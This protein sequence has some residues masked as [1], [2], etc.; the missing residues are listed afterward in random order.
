[1]KAEI[2]NIGDEILIGQIVNTNATFIAKELSKI[3]VETTQISSIADSHNDIISTLKSAQKR[4]DIIIITGGLGPTKD[5]ITKDALCD[6]F[7]DTLIKREEIVK[8]IESLFKNSIKKTVNAKT[9]NQAILPSKAIVLK[10]ELGTSPGMLFEENNKIFVS[11]PGVPFEMEALIKEQVIPKIKTAF[12]LPYIIHKTFLVY[13]II[14]SELALKLEEWEN[15]L[16]KNLKL[17]YLPSLGRVRLR[18]SG[19]DKNDSLL[20]KNIDKATKGLYNIIGDS[21][22]GENFDNLELML[23][24]IF[25]EN[26]KTLSLAESCTGGAISSTLTKIPGSS[27]YFK[28]SIVAYH[29]QSKT[30]LLDVPNEVIEEHS[31]VSEEVVK[32]MAEGVRKKYNTDIGLATSGNAGPNKGDSEAQVGTVCIAVS[33]KNKTQTFSFN[34]GNYRERVIR[35]TVSKSLELL[36]KFI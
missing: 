16:S 8:H 11:L 17:A 4:V 36:Y 33:D 21:I 9:L 19:K 34:F 24:E 18:L 13:G 7:N 31:V 20:K 27:Q 2:I 26:K 10:N 35:K 22:F 25:I 28:G 30:S 5:D 12:N 29:T 23:Q 6:F 32:Y 14:E 1:M 15:N 3:G